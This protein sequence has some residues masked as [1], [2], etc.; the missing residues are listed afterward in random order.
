LRV[1][2][3]QGGERGAVLRLAVIHASRDELRGHQA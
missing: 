2:I 1:V 3:E